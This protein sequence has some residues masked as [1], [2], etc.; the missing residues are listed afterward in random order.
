MAFLGFSAGLPFLLV[1][2]TLSAW[3]RDAEVSRATIGFF[4]WVGI[5][6]SIKVLWA[7]VIDRL[8][9]YM[10][11]SFLGRRRSWMLIAMLGVAAGLL[12]MAG[13][14][15]TQELQAVALLALLVAFSS[16]TQ[17]I[18]IDAY[19]I[20][21][22][23]EQFQGAMAATYQFGYRVALLVAGGGALLMADI[24]SWSWTYTALAG[25]MCV[26]VFTVFLISEPENRDIE[27]AEIDN[28][29]EWFISAVCRPFMDFFARNGS[30]AILILLFVGVFRISDLLMGVMANPF[31][32]DMGFSL[33]EIGVVTKFY[34]TIATIV[35]AFVG[36][37]LVVKFGILRPLFLAAVLLALTNL[38]F[39]FLAGA[40]ANLV[41]LAGT[42]TADNF[43]AGLGGAIF[44]AY[45][46]SLTNRLYTATQY[47][48]FTS[49]MT[50][51]GK[52]LGGFSGIFV[53]SYGYVQF[54]IIA[55]LAGIP[56]I[57]MVLILMRNQGN[58]RA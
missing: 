44:I 4:S 11:T 17:D 51:P 14:D 27:V 10:L 18:A 7:P 5:T 37:L 46:S 52:S 16:A 23:E 20:E 34:G 25:L 45:L 39:A 28:V 3:L 49:V 22:V 24:I 9:I 47:A 41:L 33:T 15:P 43:S 38:L 12:G 42:I 36:G 30:F 31:Y 2:S 8:P 21:I 6:Y 13:V 1:F 50:L 53:D 58:R 48:L 56:A 54:F 40:G 55:A 35:G 19:R 29:V 57:L 32:I 26:G